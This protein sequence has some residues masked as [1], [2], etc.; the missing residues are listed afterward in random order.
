MSTVTPKLGLTK[1]AGT[2]QFNLATYNNNL[3]IVDT[4]S[5]NQATDIKK[6]PKILG[7]TS[8]VTWGTSPT[9]SSDIRYVSGTGAFTTDASGYI[10]VDMP[11]S[12]PNGYMVVG[13]VNGDD[14]ARPAATFHIS[15]GVFTNTA[16]RFYVRVYQ[17]TTIVAS[18]LVRLNYFVVGH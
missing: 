18:S 12:F 3:D 14:P 4:D 10:G 11:A 6:A 5:T 2:E 7:V 15:T 17:G 9:T 13:M 1:P 8:G 16:S